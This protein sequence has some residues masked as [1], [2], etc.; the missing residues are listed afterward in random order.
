VCHDL[1]CTFRCFVVE[2][3][4]LNLGWRTARSPRNI[5]STAHQ[6]PGL[7]ATVTHDMTLRVWDMT[8]KLMRE[9]SSGGYAQFYTERCGR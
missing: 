7:V 9:V 2:L 1:A 5:T 8:T 4:Y 6:I 3:C